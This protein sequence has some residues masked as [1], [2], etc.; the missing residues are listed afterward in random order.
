VGGVVSG[1]KGI[2]VW[3]VL[4]EEGGMVLAYWDLTGTSHRLLLGLA[5]TETA[6]W[7]LRW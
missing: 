1:I 7:L 3:C 5:A 4:L 6:C 2:D